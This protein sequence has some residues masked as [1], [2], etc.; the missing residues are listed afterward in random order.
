MSPHND[1]Y[2]ELSDTHFGGMNEAAMEQFFYANNPLALKHWTMNVVETLMIVGAVWGLVHAW[3]ALKQRGEPMGMCIWWASIIFLFVVEVPVYFPELFGRT[4]NQVFFI[5]NEFSL[6]LLFNM[7]PL[8]IMAL[9]PALS[10]PAYLLV[11]QLGIFEQRGGV[12]LGAVAGAFV[13]L[14]FYQI[15]DHFGPQFGWWL[16]DR[17]NPYL[18]LGLASVPF[19]SIVGYSLSGPLSLFLLT[20]LIIA[21]FVRRRKAAAVGWRIRDGVLL[22]LLTVIVGVLTPLCIP[23]VYPPAYYAALTSAPDAGVLAA[24]YWGIILLVGA[25]GIWQF[26]RGRTREAELSAGEAGAFRYGRTFFAVYLAVFAALWL[27]ALPEYLAADAG[28]T[29]RATPIG[30]IGFVAVCF[31]VCGFILWKVRT[32]AR[33]EG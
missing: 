20:G 17:E 1:R 14:P 24:L 9:Y 7:T 12:I 5:H 25:V 4:N 30:S 3:R 22:T 29:A 2:R 33:A 6:G 16:W 10:Y 18:E 19:G 15:F 28:L 13:F 26:A 27:Y 11:K 32:A 8:Y 23:F 21:P 31:A